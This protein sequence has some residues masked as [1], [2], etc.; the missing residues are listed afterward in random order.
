MK[1]MEKPLQKKLTRMRRMT[2]GL[3]LLGVT[4]ALAETAFP[5]GLA[6]LAG[7]EKRRP[8]RRMLRHPVTSARSSRLLLRNGAVALAVVAS[9]YLLDF[10]YA[11]KA[12]EKSQ[13]AYSYAGRSGFPKP[14]EEM[15]GTARDFDAPKDMRQP[16]ALQSW[17]RAGMEKFR[18]LEE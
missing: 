12:V 14:P 11:Q 5:G 3:G 18:Q 8:V 7:L 9:A 16:R 10:F 15:R 13:I 6:R 2:Q 1:T 4:F 17:L